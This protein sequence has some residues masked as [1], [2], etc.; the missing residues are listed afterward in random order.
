MASFNFGAK[1]HKFL[2][3]WPVQRKKNWRLLIV[4]FTFFGGFYMCIKQVPGGHVGLL[5]DKRKKGVVLPDVYEP[6]MVILHNPLRYEPVSFRTFPIKKKLVREFVTKDKKIVEVL[7]QAKMEPKVAYAPEIM[8][9][10]GK[11]YGKRY[12]EEELSIDLASV[13]RQHT[14]AELV[15]N[16]EH[17]DLIVDELLKRFFEASSFHKIRMSETSVVFRDPL[18]EEDDF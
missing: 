9:R 8:G 12:L 16:D 18:A 14:F 17:T 1:F 3:D 15:A 13:I 10:F 2:Y 6:N 11:D 7:L 5:L 4:S